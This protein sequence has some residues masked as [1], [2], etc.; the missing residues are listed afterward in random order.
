MGETV[1]WCQQHRY[2]SVVVMYGKSSFS[3][4]SSASAVVSVSPDDFPGAV[5][6]GVSLFRSSL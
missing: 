1:G 3:Q 6:S 4:L 5:F 2:I